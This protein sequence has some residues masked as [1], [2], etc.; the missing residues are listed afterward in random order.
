MT[1]AMSSISPPLYSPLLPLLNSLPP[2]SKVT[3][4]FPPPRV[5]FDVV[6][7]M[8][9]DVHLSFFPIPASAI[10]A[11]TAAG[12]KVKSSF[13]KS[14]GKRKVAESSRT[15]LTP[16]AKRCATITPLAATQTHTIGRTAKILWCSLPREFN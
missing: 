10:E 4:K 1:C 5:G 15:S 11:V 8:I 13:T 3:P 9:W 6:T 14:M 16:A 12:R 2:M 7:E